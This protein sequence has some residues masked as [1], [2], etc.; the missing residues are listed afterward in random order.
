MIHV[1]CSTVMDL[2]QKYQ[3]ALILDENAKAYA[4]G[5]YRARPT[6]PK[7]SGD[8]VFLTYSRA[9]I[10]KVGYQYV[11]AIVDGVETEIKPETSEFDTFKTQFIIEA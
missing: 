11:T 4:S 2:R 6:S 9:L 5:Y 8:M 1:T 7:Y 3:A 10:T